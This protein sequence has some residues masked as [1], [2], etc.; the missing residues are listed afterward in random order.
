M[1]LAMV[2]TLAAPAAQASAANELG[3]AL[4]TATS[5]DEVKTADNVAVDA[6]VD[7]KYYGAPSNYMDLEPTWTSSNPEV[8]EVTQKGEVT[9][10][11]DGVATITI[12]LNDGKTG[13]IEITVGEGEV[14]VTTV[15]PKQVSDT[16][17]T[18]TFTNAPANLDDMVFYYKIGEYKVYYPYQLASYKDG[19][20]TVNSYVSFTDGVV[21][22]FEVAGLNPEFTATIGEVYTIV[23]SYK[24]EGD[25]FKAYA[26]KDT[27][28]SY[29]LLN[30]KGVDITNAV[31]GTVEYSFLA[32]SETGAYW[33]ADQSKGLVHFEEE[34]ASAT[35]VIKYFTGKY[36]EVT[37][38]PIVGAKVNVP[39]VSEKVAPFSIDVLA[40]AVATL[41]KNNDDIDWKKASTIIALEDD[42]KASYKLVATLK[43]NKG[44]D[45]LTTSTEYGNFSFAS[46]NNA[47]L[48]VAED[49]TIMT[50]AT[51][52]TQVLVYFTAAGANT[53]NVVAVVP[54]D[55]RA[56]R[57]VST[58]TAKDNKTAVT[59]S[60][61]S[62]YNTDS[63]EVV[64]KD[65]LGADISGTVTVEAVTKA[66]TNC[67]VPTA[68]VAGNVISITGA[69]DNVPANAKS[70]TYTFAAKCSGKTVNFSVT[71]RRPDT[72]ISG[73]KV[74]FSGDKDI[75]TTANANKYADFTLYWLSNGVK[76]GT[77]A[78][79]AKP[80]KAADATVG[81]YY[82]TVTKAS[83][84]LKLTTTT[85]Q[86]TNMVENTTVASPDAISVVDKSMDGKGGVGTYTVVVYQAVGT[87]GA[88]ASGFRQIATNSLTVEDKQD[89]MG[90]T[91]TK[92][93]NV[94]E[95]STV[96]DA[97]MQGFKFTY[98]NT[99]Y[100]IKADG[101][102]TYGNVILVPYT[103]SV[104]ENGVLAS[105]SVCFVKSVDFYI[106]VGGG[107]YVKYNVVVNDYVEVK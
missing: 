3:I 46:T 19:V 64:L 84:D 69:N 56:K 93:R 67:V 103:N 27:A 49:G 90:S 96:V 99:A 102:S 80:A 24:S 48:Y 79:E 4:Q 106:P 100:E 59:V 13:S 1:A 82:F 15:E 37:Y 28:I 61:V 29:K 2:V 60:T 54:V 11:K 98:G 42:D 92:V 23:P 105:G 22:G 32:E 12:A 26:T 87:A 6:T 57:A 50:N 77:K 86:L 66:P 74:E 63:V 34:G 35:V 14:K 5:K 88:S 91:A 10:V 20:A 85:I 44:K 107:A 43:S 45:V 16:Q 97:V 71:V 21:Y 62:P 30:A 58:M 72:S 94:V 68:T 40:G 25:D 55:V 41:Q 78:M 9:G 53:K 95:A 89:V 7:Y 81:N 104:V 8:A 51:G 52:V 75:K 47:K 83:T 73:Y 65:Q 38:E 33:F 101:T 70:Y 36:D 31:S 39:M 18:L 17:V 76:A